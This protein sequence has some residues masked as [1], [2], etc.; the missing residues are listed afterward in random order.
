L[1]VTRQRQQLA[2]S[3]QVVV[4]GQR[5]K[6]Q[7]NKRQSARFLQSLKAALGRACFLQNNGYYIMVHADTVCYVRS[8]SHEYTTRQP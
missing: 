1:E 8:S 2:E 6:A 7:N 4:P 3:E 5:D